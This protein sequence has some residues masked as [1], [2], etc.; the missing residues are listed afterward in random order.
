MERKRD[1]VFLAVL[2][3]ESHSSVTHDSTHDSIRDSGL[4][5]TAEV[6]GS[7]FESHWN[8]GEPGECLGEPVFPI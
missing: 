5:L 2:S 4:D 6:Q 8:N 7:H 3:S 1:E